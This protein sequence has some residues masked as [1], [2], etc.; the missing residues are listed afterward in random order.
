MNV[1]K[2]GLEVELKGGEEAYAL[3]QRI[4]ESI[5]SLNK[6]KKFKTLG[7][8]NSAKQEL[9]D[10]IEELDKLEKRS[11]QIRKAMESWGDP[12]KKSAAGQRLSEELEQAEKRAEEIRGSIK[13]MGS[14]MDTVTKKTR[15]FG[16]E[17]RSIN[18]F[19]SQIGGR[20]QTLGNTL[21]SFPGASMFQ[22]AVLGMGYKALN[23]LT[24]GLSNSFERSDVMSKYVKLMAEYEKANYSAEQSKQDL[25]ASIQGLPIALD[26][27][28]SLAQ[29][30][31]LSL[32]DMERGTQLAIATNNA[33]L[34]SMATESQRYQGMLQ[35]QDLMNGKELTGREWMSLGSSMGKAINEVGLQLGYSK[36]QLGKF[37]QEL[38]AGNIA[39]KDFLDAL[40]AVGTGEGVLV[41]LAKVSAQTWEGLFSNV[42]IAITRMGQG[43]I[44]TFNE[45]FAEA[46]GGRTLMQQLLGIDAEGNEVGDGLKHWINGISTAMQ[47]WIRAHPEEIVE[48]FNALKSIDWT[49][50]VQGFGEGLLDIMGYIKDFAEWAEGKDL[51]WIGRWVMKLGNI[52][53][54][55]GILGGLIRGT[56]P[57][58]ALLVALIKKAGKGGLVGMLGKLLGGGTA[59]GGGVGG[60]LIGAGINK[61]TYMGVGK[62]GL[63]AAEITGIVGALTT[64]VAGFAA[65]DMKLLSS[66]FKSF[67]EMT[68]SLKGGLENLQQIKSVDVDMG[69]IKDLVDKIA[70]VDDTL[71]EAKL[72]A[73]KSSR[74]AKATE[75]IRNTVWQL[76]RAAY[77]IN[78]A[79]GTVVDTGGFANFI[80]D[81]NNALAQLKNIDEVELDITLKLSAAFDR[82]TTAVVRKIVR[83]KDKIKQA[84][85]AIPNH[86]TK[87]ISISI[88]ATVNTA[89]AINS[90]NRGVSAVSRIASEAVPT[91]PAK[92]GMIYR[93]K[94]GDVAWKRRGT[95]TVPA[96][97]TPGEYVHNKRAVDMFGIDFMRKV[98]S[99]DMKGAMN[100]LMHRAGSM[101]NINRGTTITNNTYNNQKATINVTT[102]SAEFTGRL[103]SRF[104]GAF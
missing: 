2:V 39:S 42:K 61:G 64:M 25:D 38:Y 52:G 73:W 6:K 94:G 76:R 14:D 55:I 50:L 28:M 80:T 91:F 54:G 51:S 92:G 34:A 75:N 7:G 98:N 78:Q 33:F 46:N 58:F 45:V 35:L 24:D 30:Y 44:D 90:I 56:S 97:L 43:V 36:D 88:T 53:T 104:V 59:V 49:S 77:Q 99:L 11:E 27:A 41:D 31:T 4:D 48:F 17:W 47:D 103:A 12:F 79:A 89:G 81:I 72:S 62:I 84:L 60:E 18:S 63:L 3:L 16:Q 40:I 21:K 100:E 22:G 68:E 13:G 86:M 67:K 29:R 9:K 5:D 83:A 1:P 71:K 82:T 102:N 65:L 15:T 70:R 10:Y 87:N 23:T 96:M 101:A 26:E 66:A 8:L 19:L 93:A 85:D 37:R 20:L 32:G 95:D 57:I 74:Y 69:T